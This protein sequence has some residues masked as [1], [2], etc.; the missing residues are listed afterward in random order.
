MHT[1]THDRKHTDYVYDTYC[2]YSEILKCAIPVVCRN[3]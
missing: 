1:E 2:Q 3:K